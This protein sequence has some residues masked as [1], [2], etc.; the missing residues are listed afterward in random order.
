MAEDL[1]GTV[2]LGM[3]RSGTSSVTRMF[4]S[5]GFH[6]GHE[7]ELMGAAES[8]PTGHWENLRIF[9]L[10]ERVLA[11][12]GGSWFDPP[13][14]AAQRA[15]REWALPLIEAE[16]DRLLAQADGRPIVVKDPRIG[17]MM[18]LWAEPLDR[19][20]PVLVVRDPI[21][22]A[23]SL[24]KR[25]GTPLPFGLAAWELHMCSLLSHLQGRTVTVAPYEQLIEERELAGLVVEA[26]AA[27][28]H[29]SLRG[30]VL[31]E[32]A[33]EAFD[34]EL[35]RNRAD[36]VDRSSHLTG[37]QAQLWELLGALPAGDQ[38]LEPPAELRA[39]SEAALAAVRCETER[40]ADEAEHDRANE[41]AG[42]LSRERE[43]SA[44]LAAE[45]DAERDRAATALQAHEQA[46]RWLEALQGS[47][48]WRLTRPLR[49][50]KRL[51][52]K[53][54]RQSA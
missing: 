54:A 11:E 39:A 15:A 24:R 4:A 49:V 47:A 21:E 5:A 26:A 22:V 29:R 7:D 44:L 30:G 10:N 12:L 28:L 31:P 19:L 2:V 37:R 18:P 34:S 16:V 20:H 9:R 38:T 23:L 42:A 46:E 8:N 48:S 50:A 41:L 45:L 3:G 52:R 35:R 43:R 13:S 17:V 53:S 14:S 27:R 51:L 6:P 25:D 40:V 1:H 32:R 33:G 36:G